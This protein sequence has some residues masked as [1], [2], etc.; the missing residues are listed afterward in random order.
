MPHKHGNKFNLL[1]TQNEPVLEKN[2]MNQ[3]TY[4]SLK[5]AK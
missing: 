5:Y 3:E 1:Q 4:P 2:D